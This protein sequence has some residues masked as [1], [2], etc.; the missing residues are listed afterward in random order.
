MLP[1]RQTM[2][3]EENDFLQA[4]L[5]RTAVLVSVTM[6]VSNFISLYA[7]KFMT[8]L[9]VDTYSK[10]NG[11]RHRNAHDLLVSEITKLQL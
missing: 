5:L 8:V 10:R 4:D 1:F 2:R 6:I 9:S 11:P 7:C 3:E